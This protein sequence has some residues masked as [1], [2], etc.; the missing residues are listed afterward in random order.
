MLVDDINSNRHHLQ[1]IFTR[2]DDAQDAVFTLKQFVK[3]ELLSPE[4][5]TKLS[6][7]EDMDLPAISAV[8]NETKIGQGLKFLPQTLVDI[9]LITNGTGKPTVK[10]MLAKIL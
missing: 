5:F 4:L 1:S 3:E 9:A 10:N 2:L 7:L 6:E 8:I